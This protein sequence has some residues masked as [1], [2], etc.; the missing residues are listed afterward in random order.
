MERRVAEKAEDTES[1]EFFRLGGLGSLCAS[2]FH[3]IRGQHNS[4][5]FTIVEAARI[6]HAEQVRSS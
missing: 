5:S 4:W 1:E 6:A 2:A 3:L